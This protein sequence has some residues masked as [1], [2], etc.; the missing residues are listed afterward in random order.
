MIYRGT[1]LDKLRL[2]IKTLPPPLGSLLRLRRPVHLL[3]RGILTTTHALASAFP[4][5]SSIHDTSTLISGQPRLASAR[6]QTRNA[7][8]S[9]SSTGIPLHNPVTTG[10]K[11]HSGMS[12][13]TFS[14]VLN[15]HVRDSQDLR[16]FLS[17]TPSAVAQV[18]YGRTIPFPLEFLI[19]TFLYHGIFPFPHWPLL[20]RSIVTRLLLFMF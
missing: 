6:N 19:D 8:L 13:Q 2:S 15:I 17:K 3:R 12:C 11:T 4:L 10:C 16:G 1:L 14:T 20:I 9:L 7:A 18:A 5:G